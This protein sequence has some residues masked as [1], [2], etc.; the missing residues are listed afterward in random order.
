MDGERKQNRDRLKVDEG[1]YLLSQAMSFGSPTH[2][3]YI[4]VHAVIA[5]AC[6]AVLKAWYDESTVIPDAVQPK[7]PRS[8]PTFR[9]KTARR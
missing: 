9:A 7:A 8:S 3:S 4:S 1:S 6:I 5:G 2:P